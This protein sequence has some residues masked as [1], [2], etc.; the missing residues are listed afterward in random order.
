VGLW[1]S[2]V[3]WLVLDPLEMRSLVCG[4][5][6]KDPPG[7]ARKQGGN[8]FSWKKVGHSTVPCPGPDKHPPGGARKRGGT[9]SVGKK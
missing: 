7:G 4:R 5:E 1:G 8:H 3:S 9:T 2:N 6:S